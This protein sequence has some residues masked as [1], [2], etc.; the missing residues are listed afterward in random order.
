M[1]DPRKVRVRVD[2]VQGIIEEEVA[3]SKGGMVIDGSSGV[4]GLSPYSTNSTTQTADATLG[5]GSGGV[6]VMSSS[7]GAVTLTL[8]DASVSPGMLLTARNGSEHAHILTASQGPSIIAD[9][10]TLGDTITMAA[11]LNASAVLQSDG[12]AW[13][14]L[15]SSGSVSIS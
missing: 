2:P 5:A 13:I 1:S 6:Q 15:G 9:S 10:T 8:P 11:Q 7:T 14:V 4:S 12:S 3:E